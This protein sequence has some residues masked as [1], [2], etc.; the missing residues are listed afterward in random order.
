MEPDLSKRPVTR[1]QAKSGNGQRDA[2]ERG[3]IE[4]LLSGFALAA[5]IDR[6][7]SAFHFH[8]QLRVLPFAF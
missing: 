7:A 2:L 1:K 3:R 4:Q 6:F 8:D 5:E